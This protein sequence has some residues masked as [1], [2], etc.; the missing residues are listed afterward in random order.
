MFILSEGKTETIATTTGLGI[1]GTRS[2][3][4]EMRNT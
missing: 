4:G 2:T 1:G 3:N